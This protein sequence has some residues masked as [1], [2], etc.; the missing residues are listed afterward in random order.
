MTDKEKAK[1]YDEAIKKAKE[2]KEKIVY[3]HLSTE[4]CKAVSEYIDTIIPELRESEDEKIIKRLL[5]LVKILDPC[6]FEGDNPSKK[7]CL[8]W[9]EKQ[10][11]NPKIADSIP[12]DCASN[13]KCEDRGEIPQEFIDFLGARY[14]SMDTYYSDCSALAKTDAPILWAIAAK[15]FKE[16]NP[17]AP[18]DDEKQKEQGDKPTGLPN[19]KR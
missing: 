17:P 15:Y 19:G 14:Q 5:T 16:V 4:S 1:A 10:K 18:Y 2:I 12:A 6:F 9:L 8:A 13:A 11:E 7:E 3:S